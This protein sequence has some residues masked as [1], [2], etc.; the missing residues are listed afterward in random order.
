MSST[1]RRAGLTALLLLFVCAAAFLQPPPAEAADPDIRLV[2]ILLSGWQSELKEPDAADFRAAWDDMRTELGRLALAEGGTVRIVPYSY[3]GTSQKTTAPL[4]KGLATYEKCQANQSL[5][6]SAKALDEQLKHWKSEYPN[7]KFMLVGHSLGGAVATYWAGQSS[8]DL[9]KVS[10]I[11]TIDSPVRGVSWATES[12]V[13]SEVFVVKKARELFTGNQCDGKPN[14]FLKQLSPDLKAD[15]VIDGMAKASNRL[16]GRVHHL[17]NPG[18][19]FVLSEMQSTDAGRR[20]ERP[21]DGRYANCSKAVVSLV[22]YP[23]AGTAADYLWNTCQDM[24][25]ALLHDAW[26]HQQVVAIAKTVLA[27][28]ADQPGGNRVRDEYED[29]RDQ[30]DGL[31]GWIN[32]TLIPAVQAIA[33]AVAAVIEALG[34]FIAFIADLIQQLQ[35]AQEEAAVTSEFLKRVQV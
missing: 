19:M 15:G 21:L 1:L 11:V 30:I 16:P 32:D 2:V 13:Q 20:L 27:E 29:A 14:G 18:D 26:A 8:S 24:H 10:A 31:T 5:K 35:D 22:A 3:G 28:P 9:K 25:Q 34:R 12:V 33:G 17:V 7:A 6:T 4:L 23:S